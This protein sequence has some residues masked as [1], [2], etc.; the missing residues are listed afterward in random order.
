MSLYTHDNA[1]LKVNNNFNKFYAV[2]YDAIDRLAWSLTHTISFGSLFTNQSDFVNSVR[3]YPFK[4]SDYVGVGALEQIQI[5]SFKS[6]ASGKPFS[7]GVSRRL[8]A[9]VTIGESIVDGGFLNYSPYTKLELYLP[10]I[11]F[12]NLD[13]SLVI[14]KRIDV[15]YSVDFDTGGVTASLEWHT[16]GGV[17]LQTNGVIG[18]DIPLGA[19]NANDNARTLLANGLSLVGGVITSIATDNPLPLV[20]SGLSVTSSVSQMQERVTKGGSVSGKGALANPYS[21]YLIRTFYKPIG[22]GAKEYAPYKGRPLMETRILGDMQGF[23]R[24][25]SIHIDDVGDAT[26]SERAE[27]ERLLQLGVIL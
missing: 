21:V 23:T 15:F 24:V 17:I 5:G 9:S 11:G 20:M 16:D 27:L 26:E 19:T 6:T 18:F 4:I 14:G 1:N 7:L 8:I 3:V 25:K 22:E 10:F 13:P 2:E 12:V